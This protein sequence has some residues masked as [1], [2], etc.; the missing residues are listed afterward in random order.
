AWAGKQAKLG[1][2]EA[3]LIPEP[4]SAFEG[5]LHY[6]S[7]AEFDEDEILRVGKRPQ[8]AT[9]LRQLLRQSGVAEALPAPARAALTRLASRMQAFQRT[10]VLLLGPDLRIN[11]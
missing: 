6:D 4:K 2:P 9:R 1:S 7:P 3:K 5:L 8:T 11:P 10:E